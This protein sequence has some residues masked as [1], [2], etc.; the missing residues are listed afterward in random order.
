[1]DRWKA[2]HEDYAQRFLHRIGSHVEVYRLEFMSGVEGA[3]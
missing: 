2:S 1:M 3:H